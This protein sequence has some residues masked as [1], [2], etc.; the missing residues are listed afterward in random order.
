VPAILELIP[1]AADFYT[2]KAKEGRFVYKNPPFGYK[3]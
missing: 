3:K 2:A 1:A